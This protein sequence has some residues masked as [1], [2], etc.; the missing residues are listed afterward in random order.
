MKEAYIKQVYYYKNYYLDFFQSLNSDV[1]KNF[2]RTIKLIATIES[3]P[4]KFLKHI[5]NTDGLYEVRVEVET[6][7]YR[8]FCFFDKG[9][10]IIL[11]NGFRKKSKRTSIREIELAERIKKNY[12]YEKERNEPFDL[13]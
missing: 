9:K 2:N 11:I 6:D 1:K 4:V 7:M 10:L 3:V 5:E 12:F 8:V 13:I